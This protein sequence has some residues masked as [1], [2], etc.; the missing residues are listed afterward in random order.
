MS[1]D[2]SNSVGTF[3]ARGDSS[4]DI[5]LWQVATGK[6]LKKWQV[7]DVVIG[8]GGANAIVVS[9]SE[10][11]TCKSLSREK[12]LRN[13]VF[14][15]IIDAIALDPGEDVFYAGG[16][17]RKIYIATVNIVADPNNNYGLH[18]LGFLSKQRKL[19]SG[20]KKKKKR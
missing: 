15:T 2:V 4:G 20:A 3:I 12:S 1:S 6:L 9:A 8:Y 19:G 14:P 11:R 17:D 18:I 16:R 10:D 5:Y 13:I 7:T